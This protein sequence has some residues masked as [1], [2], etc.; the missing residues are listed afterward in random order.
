VL[1]TV[2]TALLA[3]VLEVGMLAAI[4]ETT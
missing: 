2:G 1:L 4:I 3:N